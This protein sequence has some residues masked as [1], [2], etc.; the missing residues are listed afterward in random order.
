MSDQPAER[1]GTA[2]ERRARLVRAGFVLVVGVPV[3]ALLTGVLFAGYHAGFVTLSRTVELP[4][5][6][7]G[8]LGFLPGI[9]AVEAGVPTWYGS[10]L[11]VLT[12]AAIFAQQTRD[13]YDYTAFNR[14][15]YL[16]RK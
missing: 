9:P 6:A 13:P 11:A 2:G 16:R 10:V 3:F 12:T 5:V 7:P 4:V 1:G 15:W 8:L 14:W